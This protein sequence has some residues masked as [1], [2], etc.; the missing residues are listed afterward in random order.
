MNRNNKLVLS[1]MFG[2]S[3]IGMEPPFIAN[4]VRLISHV[5]QFSDQTD[6]E[7]CAIYLNASDIEN[8]DMEQAFTEEASAYYEKLDKAIEKEW[9]LAHYD[10]F[11]L[12]DS[13]YQ[14]FKHGIGICAQAERIYKCTT[15]YNEIVAKTNHRSAFYPM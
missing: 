8:E 3:N 15:C 1:A 10:L 9:R 7:A 11:A 14:I 5:E 2:R 13:A 4:I 12:Y 6:A